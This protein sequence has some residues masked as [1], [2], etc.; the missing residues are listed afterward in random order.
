MLRK[1]LP[2]K[3]LAYSRGVITVHM[4]SIFLHGEN[5]PHLILLLYHNL[6]SDWLWVLLL[7]TWGVCCVASRTASPKKRV[8]RE[9][10]ICAQTMI[11]ILSSIANTKLYILGGGGPIWPFNE[12]MK[13]DKMYIRDPNIMRKWLWSRSRFANHLLH[14]A[15]FIS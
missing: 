7:Y 1:K 12:Y 6:L 4:I 5:L 10:G 13:F 2:K 14:I 3:F 11:T 9:I 15:C 8:F